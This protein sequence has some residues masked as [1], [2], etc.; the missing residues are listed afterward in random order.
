MSKRNDN[1]EKYI[2]AIIQANKHSNKL[3]IVDARPK[4]NAIANVAMGG[5]YEHDDNYLNTEFSFLDIG[6]IHVMRER[7]P[8]PCVVI[9]Q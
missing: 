9:L 8:L 4:I 7:R 3:Y 2:Q 1:D 6:N 5:G